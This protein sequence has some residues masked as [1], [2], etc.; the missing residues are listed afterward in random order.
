MTDGAH[1]TGPPR[2]PVIL[3]HREKGGGPDGPPYW[4]R[5]LC[6]ASTRLPLVRAACS[7]AAATPL[8]TTIASKMGWEIIEEQHI[9]STLNGEKDGPKWRT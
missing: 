1:V 6:L 4:E 8:L 2:V 7:D 3:V 5:S 9:Y